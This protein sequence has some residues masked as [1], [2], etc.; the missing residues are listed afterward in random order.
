MAL[1]RKNI[2]VKKRDLPLGVE[3]G[4]PLLGEHIPALHSQADM[5]TVYRIWD[6]LD[7]FPAGEQE[8]ALHRLTVLLQQAL[9]ADNVK[10]LAVGRAALMALWMGS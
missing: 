7:R 3:T 1:F 4:S 10:W 2:G 8:S 6:E 5:A 9:R